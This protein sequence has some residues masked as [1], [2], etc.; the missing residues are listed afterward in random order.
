[1][2]SA[3]A[4][5]RG[6]L[7]ASP[8]SP[9]AVL[10]TCGGHAFG[11]PLTAVRE[12]LGPQPL[13]RLPGCGDA[14]GG[15]ANVRG[16]VLT[17]FDLGGALGIGRSSAREDHRLLLLAR[18]DRQAAFAVDSVLGVKRAMAD[19][20]SIDAAT[21]RALDIDPGDV[22]GIGTHDDTPFLLLDPEPLFRRFLK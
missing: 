19:D 17:V 18:G 21:L 13:T 8:A 11:L 1:M 16:R 6:A 22:I 10:F 7:V 12:V 2:V 3:S 4:Q 20:P 15:L 14:V 5:A 9:D